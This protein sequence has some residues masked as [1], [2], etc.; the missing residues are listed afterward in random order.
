MRTARYAAPVR[1]LPGIALFALTSLVSTSA[2]AQSWGARLVRV[3]D[4]FGRADVLTDKNGRIAVSAVLPA[5]MS[6]T[7]VGLSPFDDSTASMRML[8]SQ[9]IA[10]GE[11]H[12]DIDIFVG[13]PLKPL[14]TNS[15]R[16][17]R[18]DELRQAYPELDGS[19]VVV[20]VIDTGID[21]LHPDFRNADGTTR[22][23][24]LLQTGI[25]SNGKHPELE[26]E[27]CESHGSVCAIFNED[28]IN[29][30]IA[31]GLTGGT[32]DGTGHGT[33]V[34][35]IA[36]GNGGPSVNKTPRYIGAAPGADLIIGALE[37]F[38]DP[39]VS[40]TARFIFDR[41]DEMQKPC[42]LN[43][44]LGSDYGAHDG[45]DILDRRLSRRV[46]DD[47]PGH[48]IVAAA[49]N[50]GGLLIFEGEDVPWGIHTEAHVYPT[51]DVRVPIYAPESKGGR[52]FVWV[53]FQPGDEVSI[54][55]EGPGG[56][57][58]VAPVSPGD[59][60]GYEDGANVA[61][62]VNNLFKP[63]A[64]L[65]PV[66]NGGVVV[67]SGEW[68]DNSE[69]AIRLSG[70]G[71]AQLWVTSTGDLSLSTG[72]LFKRAIRQGTINV[73]AAAPS[74]LAVGCTIN[75][76]TWPTVNGFGKA[77]TLD[78]F[79]GDLEPE[80]DGM[81]YF[82]S[83]GP[84][85]NGLAK[86]ELSAPGGFVAAAM[87]STADP[88]KTPGSLFDVGGCPDEIPNCYLV[89]EQHAISAGT[90][91]SSPQV[92][93]AVA[94]LFQKTMLDKKPQLTQA[95]VTAVLQAGARYPEGKV[96]NETQLG[97][98]ALDVMGALR[99]LGDEEDAFANPD[100]KKSWFVLSSGYARPDLSW[101]VWGTVELRNADGE[102]AHAL[103]GTF[104]SLEVKGGAV[105][106]PLRKIRHGLYRFSV[107]G[108]PGSN[109][110]EMTI[111]V[112]YK[113]VSLG[114]K[115]IPIGNDVWAGREPL[116][117]VGSCSVSSATL[118]LPVERGASESTWYVIALSALAV[119]TAG[120]Q[121]RRPR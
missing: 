64:A 54:G 17:S 119:G 83:A 120:K 86:P 65:V 55:L 99:A 23:K 18:V 79:G 39:D 45:S 25:P 26:K 93:G 53:T 12:P 109:G 108:E 102:V 42:V 78:E 46:G 62:V 22:I 51:A 19:G 40:D 106:Q 114:V 50:S 110:K 72:L 10:L 5:G 97:P 76:L 43:V 117:A 67:W 15:A 2:F 27:Y 4:K 31:Q 89:D 30:A 3:F 66:T 107:T 36:A 48:A 104:L 35:S 98:G 111:D 103:D 73:P 69:F 94:L 37:S 56:S 85:P 28:D 29:Q 20:A 118:G 21:V 63:S 61:G 68:A 115:T 59:E 9:V 105:L 44:S 116:G 52:G 92:A 33:H 1:K 88:R 6:A 80:L 11:A 87:A 101:P 91:M 38:D 47:Q 95:Q 81:C 112:Q 100:P 60:R 77:I 14:L 82:S 41:A 96:P 8:P 113:G 57:T 24:W 13:P 7:S 74:L 49:G 34:A 121:R 75:R 71:H 90:S 16:W 32:Y 70:R 84:T 58:W